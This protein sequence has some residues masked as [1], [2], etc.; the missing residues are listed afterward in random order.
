[1]KMSKVWEILRKFKE[2]CSFRGWKTSESND[3]VEVNDKYHNF[4]LARKVH[5]TSFKSIVA[6]KKCVVQE[7]LSYR[8]VETSYTAWLFSEAPSETLFKMLYENSDFSKR[9]AI[10]DLSSLEGKNLCVKLNHTDSP[11]FREFERF[12]KEKLKVK[13]KPLSSPNQG[14]DVKTQAIAEAT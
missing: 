5:P 13:F 4:L 14:L 8:V 1:M 6:N 11:V 9:I 12:L 2:L 7:G 10:Y 3:W